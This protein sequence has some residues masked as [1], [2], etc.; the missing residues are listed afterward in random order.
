MFSLFLLFSHLRPF[1]RVSF[2]TSLCEHILLYLFITLR[3]RVD[4]TLTRPRG[5]N[6]FAHNI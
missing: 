3:A 5:G 4:Y 1:I 6:V 2:T